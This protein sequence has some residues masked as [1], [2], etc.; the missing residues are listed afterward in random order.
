LSKG[1]AMNIYQRLVERMQDKDTD[2][3]SILITGDRVEIYT[4]LSF[5]D[6]K[7]LLMEMIMIEKDNSIVH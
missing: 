7:A 5:D 6:L 2:Y 1:K 4:S 3:A